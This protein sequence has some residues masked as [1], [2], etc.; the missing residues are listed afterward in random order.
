MTGPPADPQV[1]AWLAGPAILSLEVPGCSGETLWL[2]SPGTPLTVGCLAPPHCDLRGEEA[3]APGDGALAAQWARGTCV[4]RRNPLAVEFP[5]F[6]CSLTSIP[7]RGRGEV[8]DPSRSEVCP[9]PGSCRQDWPCAQCSLSWAPPGEEGC[10]AHSQRWSPEAWAGRGVAQ[11][12]KRRAEG[13]ARQR[14]QRRAW[15]GGEPVTS[16]VPQS[17]RE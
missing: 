9:S 10:W 17:E 2:P 8:G 6:P 16:G 11:G 5:F 3:D 13:C 1:G 7:L 4:V 15:P 14:V 12:R